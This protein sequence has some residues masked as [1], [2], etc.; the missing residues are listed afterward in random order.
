M[1]N[2]IRTRIKAAWMRWREVTGVLCDKRMQI[3]LKLLIYK[4]IVQ[5]VA[6]QGTEC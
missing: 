5:P 1:E 3:C 4:T 2:E 6:L